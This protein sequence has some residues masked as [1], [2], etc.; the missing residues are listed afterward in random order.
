MIEQPSMDNARSE[1]NHSI[2]DIWDFISSDV[3]QVIGLHSITYHIQIFN[4]YFTQF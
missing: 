1:A 3:P 4:T 2:N